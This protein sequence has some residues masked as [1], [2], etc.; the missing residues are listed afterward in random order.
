MNAQ[1]TLDELELR[2]NQ[3]I[4]KAKA[5][6]DLPKSALTNNP[7]PDAWNALESIDHINRYSTF[8]IPAF[9]N[10]IAKSKHGLEP[11]YKP[12]WLGNKSAMDMLPIEDKLPRTMKTFK[13]KNPSLDGIGN[14]V[15]K[16]FVKDQTEYLTI[17]QSA[18]KVSLDKTLC[19]T[20][21]PLIKFK[22]GDALRFVIY[23]EVRHMLQAEKATS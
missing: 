21:L 4:E 12:T 18:R 3:L 6:A 7:N 17:I 15:I 22:L 8:Y 20:T 11:N 14:D 19:K 5:L 9:K 16:Q 10:A 1:E 13:S 2:L 23:H